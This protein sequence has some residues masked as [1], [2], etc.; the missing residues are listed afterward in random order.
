MQLVTAS[1]DHDHDE[2]L[3][4]K[5][6]L[7]V[8]GKAEFNWKETDYTP[9]VRDLNEIQLNKVFTS[10]VDPSLMGFLLKRKT[11]ADTREPNNDR[12]ENMWQRTSKLQ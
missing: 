5:Q 10:Q 9:L 4:W 2:G 7:Q 11:W 3:C 1:V 6:R 8:K 12:T